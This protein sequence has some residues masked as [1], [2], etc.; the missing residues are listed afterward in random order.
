MN[1]PILISNG[2]ALALTFMVNYY[3][4][5]E[6]DIDMTILEK[7]ED[8]DYLDLHHT[9]IIRDTIIH[10]YYSEES[11]SIVHRQYAVKVLTA[12]K[13]GDIPLIVYNF[14]NLPTS[15]L[16]ITSTFNQEKL[17]MEYDITK[18]CINLFMNGNFNTKWISDGYNNYLPIVNVMMNFFNVIR[19]RDELYSGYFMEDLTTDYIRLHEY[20]TDKSSGIQYQIDRPKMF[21]C[22]FKTLKHFKRNFYSHC[23]LHTKNIFIEKSTSRIK[24]IDLGLAC[25]N[26]L[27]KK[28]RKITADI[29]DAIVTRHGR[30]KLKLILINIA[31]QF[32]K[33]VMDSDLAMFVTILNIHYEIN[34][35]EYRIL[36]VLNKT[37]A[38]LIL[39]SNNLVQNERIEKM[40]NILSNFENLIKGIIQK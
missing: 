26:I 11:D 37:V 17:K 1:I 24:I 29:V 14:N 22:L 4:T 25:K 8:E 18:E 20:L 13:S 32:N 36:N 5:K 12:G 33:S 21:T 10:S 6:E 34:S 15:I 7:E 23:D 3:T 38:E 9:E 39:N 16:K 31:G 27:C 28:R 40:E 2:I 30:D 35:S 19:F